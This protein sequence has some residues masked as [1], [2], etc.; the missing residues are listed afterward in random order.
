MQHSVPVQSM[1]IMDCATEYD[2]L[3][4]QQGF[5]LSITDLLKKG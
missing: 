2:L 1:Y 3:L 5:E 4:V